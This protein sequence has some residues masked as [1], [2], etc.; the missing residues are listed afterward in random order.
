VDNL[1]DLLLDQWAV[2]LYTHQALSITDA[3]IDG[4]DR[5]FKLKKLTRDYWNDIYVF[6][7]SKQLGIPLVGKGTRRI[8][9]RVDVNCREVHCEGYRTRGHPG[10][11]L[12]VLL[13][14]G[15]IPADL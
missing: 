7:V 6:S 8:F 5:C 1:S 3:Y 12:P 10:K 11:A 14:G 9:F 15:R 13:Q 2:E 4:I